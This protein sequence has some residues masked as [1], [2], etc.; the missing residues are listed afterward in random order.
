MPPEKH[1][2]L[3][4]SK[5]HQWLACPPSAKFEA[6]F[7]DPGP[8][9]AAREGTLAHAIAEDH[10][11]KRLA[12]KKVTTPKKFRDDPLYKPAMEEH[13]ATY[14]DVILDTITAMKLTGGDP[15]V[16]LE[17]KLDLSY[18]VPEG[19]G[20]ADCV[21]IGNGVLHVFDLKYG[22]G[23]PVAAEENP[24]LKL[25]GLG[26]VEEFSMLY[27]ISEVV[28]HIIQPRLDSITEWNVS[29]DVLM[30]WGEFVVAPIAQKAFHGEGE[31]NPGEDQCRWCRAKDACRAYNSHMLELCKARFDDQGEERNPNELSPEEIVELLKNVGAIKSWANRVQ[32]YAQ[33]QALN[34]THWPGF[35]LVEGQSRRKIT[36][37]PEVINILDNAGFTTD[38]TCKLIGITDLEELVGKKQLELIGDHIVK[39]QGKPTL[40]PESDKRPPFND[41]KFA[42]VKE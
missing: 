18:W 3:G 30:K 8:S 31:F 32:E 39:P 6:S 26:A 4:A 25:Y 7:V 41:I 22:K 14:C 34:G 40:V 5:A 24:Q 12:G 17:Q 13:V 11:T 19:F 20:T 15:I 37:E 21:V 27:D 42:E 1:A 9:E 23:V 35:K 38:K 36:D 2:L 29:R 10:L 33:E 16:Y 28:L